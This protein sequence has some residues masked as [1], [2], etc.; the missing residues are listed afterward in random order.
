MTKPSKCGCEFNNAMMRSSNLG[1]S[2]KQDK[3]KKIEDTPIVADGNMEEA[4]AERG[5]KPA[6][7]VVKKRATVLD[8]ARLSSG[9]LRKNN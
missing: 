9:K 1:A 8:V 3:K 5:L 2:K 4:C 6:N 7:A